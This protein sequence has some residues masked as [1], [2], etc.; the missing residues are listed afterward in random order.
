MT[1]PGAP[2]PA[3]RLEPQTETPPAA[4]PAEGQ[5]QQA[6]SSPP[7]PALRISALP[8]LLA[9]VV[10][11]FWANV[12]F[13]NQPLGVSLPLFAGTGLLALFALAAWGHVAPAWRNVWLA[14]P[15]LFFAVLAAVRVEGLLTF[16][17]VCAVLLLGGLIAHFFASGNVAAMGILD[18]FTQGATAGLEIGL[19]RPAHALELSGRAGRQAVKTAPRLFAV[20]RGVA[21]AVPILIVFTILLTSAD[22]AFNQSVLDL[23][24]AASLD[25]APELFARVMVTGMAAWVCLGWLAQAFRAGPAPAAG[26]SASEAASGWLGFTETAVVLFSVDLLFAAFVFVQFRYFFGGQSNI[27]VA[28]FTYSEYARR[29]FGEL[30]VVAVFA[31][32]LGLIMQALTRRQS[33][34]AKYGFNGLIAALVVLTGI[35]LVSA[36]QRLRLYEEAYGFTRLRTYPHVFM[37]WVG[38]LLAAFLV[39]VLINRPRLFAFCLLLAG[40]GFVATLDLLNTDAFIAR[41]NIARY[42]QTGKLDAAYLTTLSDDAVPELLPL[43]ATAAKP[44]RDLI[45]SSLHARLNALDALKKTAGWQGWHWARAR[46]YTLLD[47]DRAELEHY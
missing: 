8:L 4:P 39:T 26:A 21:L 32:G 10:L 19:N 35:I 47:A 24:K 9:A 28:G 18:Y 36:F 12:L 44:D 7:R 25:N 42:Q 2:Q 23:L 30:V 5:T 45:G 38:V 6:A 20:L 14:L 34:A 40:L 22:A 13:I 46:A 16:M 3:T 31:L 43:L 41:Q 11:G 27:T 1:A 33:A 29:G 37:V 15:L 17:N